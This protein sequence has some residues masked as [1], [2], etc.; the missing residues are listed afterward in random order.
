MG[1]ASTKSM[2]RPDSHGDVGVTVTVI[3]WTK[4]GDVGV[5]LS[6]RISN[7]ANDRLRYIRAYQ[8]V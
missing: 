8:K 3:F 2:G 4:H 7:S 6:I 5:T 1:C